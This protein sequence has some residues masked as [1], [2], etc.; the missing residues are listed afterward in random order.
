LRNVILI[1]VL[2]VL[3]GD[4]YCMWLSNR[5]G[6]TNGAAGDG[7]WVSSTFDVDPAS[8]SISTRCGSYGKLMQMER[9]IK[10]QE[11]LGL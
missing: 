11:L 8:L 3:L 4:V 9:R 2:V 5:G 1:H 10:V 6:R 7:Q